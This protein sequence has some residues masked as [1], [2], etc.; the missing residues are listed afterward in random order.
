[1]K[2]IFEEKYL[3]LILFLIVVIGYVVQMTTFSRFLSDTRNFSMYSSWIQNQE[4]RRAIHE[5]PERY[6]GYN[7]DGTLKTILNSAD[8]PIIEKM[9]P[10]ISNAF[11]LLDRGMYPFRVLDAAKDSI[12]DISSTL[13]K[14]AGLHGFIR[15]KDGH[16]FTSK[17]RLQFAGINNTYEANFP[18]HEHA[19]L[20][21]L[22]L[23]RFGFNCVRLHHCDEKGFWGTN[24]KTVFDETKLDLFDYNIAALKKQGIYVNLNLHC[25][26][27]LG[28]NEGVIP[29]GVLFDKGIDNF[30]LS[31]RD[32][33]KKFISELLNHVNPYT[34]K[35]YKDEPAVA[36]IEINNENSICQVWRNGSL[37]NANE[38]YLY[39]LRDLWNTFLKNRYKT[40]E[41]LRKEVGFTSVPFGAELLKDTS[42]Y[43]PKRKTVKLVDK[44]NNATTPSEIITD[45]V[46]YLTV[47]G[48]KKD[49]RQLVYDNLIV[50]KGQLYTFSVVLRSDVPS[51]VLFRTVYS[52]KTGRTTKRYTQGLFETYDYTFIADNNDNNF[53]LSIGGFLEGVV[54]SVKSLSF[55]EGG[56]VEYPRT[57]DRPMV[58]EESF[59][60]YTTSLINDKPLKTLATI[61]I[62]KIS[63][64][65]ILQPPATLDLRARADK[66]YR[67]DLLVT[68]S[69]DMPFDITFTQKNEVLE[70]TENYNSFEKAGK[71]YVLS[72]NV[73]SKH[74][75]NITLN[76]TKTIRTATYKFDI[77]HVKEIIEPSNEKISLDS[78]NIPVLFY[79]LISRYPA[80]LQDDWC[81]FLMG[82]DKAYWKDMYSFIKEELGVQSLVTGTQIEYGSMYAQA[83]T[84]YCDIHGFWDHPVFPNYAWNDKDWFCHN[85][86]LINIFDK[87]PLLNMA[88]KRVA[89]KPFTVSE[90]SHTWLNRYSAEGLPLLAA[91][92][93]RHGWDG[94]FPFCYDNGAHAELES[95]FD[96][97]TMRN[98]SVQLA[99]MI[100]CNNLLTRDYNKDADKEMIVAPLSEDKELELFQKNHHT[101]SFGFNGLELDV[102]Q[103]LFYP[104]GIDASGTAEFPRLEPVDDGVNR[105][106][107][108]NNDG[109]STYYDMTTPSKHW[110]SASQGKTNVFTGFIQKERYYPFGQYFIEFGAVNLE[111][112]TV[113]MTETSRDDKGTHYLF[114]VTGEMRN[115]DQQYQRILENKITLNNSGIN[116]FGAA[117]V[118]C[119]CLS[120]NLYANT[121]NSV[122]YYPLDE[123]GNRQQE[124]YASFFGDA[125]YLPIKQ[126]N[127]DDSGWKRLQFASDYKTIWYEIVIRENTANENK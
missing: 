3:F 116:T 120:V 96:Y 62:Q 14:P 44:F 110:F 23:A 42:A 55:R 26:R 18:T 94:V 113:T 29:T 52:N 102:R 1:M 123:A 27:Y 43:L 48:Q 73:K 72:Y 76:V 111:W 121:E 118:L 74:N 36:L 71:P 81:E 28:H 103:A 58:L 32:L 92:A 22:R 51:S 97:F 99:H 21:A 41:N 49:A 86:P 38:Y 125:S 127:T 12:T 40:D 61:N 33:N 66:K 39:E 54:Y 75:S 87:S 114:V 45:D 104:T 83:A 67:V 126:R 95:L 112:A 59:D 37:E 77:L 24:N 89:G 64:G 69:T 79:S 82:L 2:K 4:L 119:E 46:L 78:M 63:D 115:T 100:A 57:D 9:T 31:I 10:E 105:F 53:R 93:G 19:D 20:T 124:S 85:Q 13:D 88:T 91:L 17:G 70:T 7:P 90:Y 56:S 11:T 5:H 15:V 107:V 35:A 30:N 60:V 65:S 34:G 122:V 117:P 101:Y 8:N 98:N 84:D 50:K 68:A 108:L 106:A 109:N 80:K 25:S 16:F 47:T 6:P